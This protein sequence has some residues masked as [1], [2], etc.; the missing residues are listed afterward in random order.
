[1]NVTHGCKTLQELLFSGM[2]TMTQQ[3]KST[4][5]GGI[6]SDICFLVMLNE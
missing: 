1:M 4:E 3:C 2:D 5:S 6:F